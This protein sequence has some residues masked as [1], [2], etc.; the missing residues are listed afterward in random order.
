MLEIVSF[1]W[2]TR[3]T[4]CSLHIEVLL[5]KLKTV[6]Y[7]CFLS[8]RFHCEDYCDT[9]YPSTFSIS[10]KFHALGFGGPRETEYVKRMSAN[11][12]SH[13]KMGSVT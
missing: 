1:S 11:F 12:W 9:L 5:V 13:N 2:Q 6:C 8:G 10:K 4:R 3:A 7:E